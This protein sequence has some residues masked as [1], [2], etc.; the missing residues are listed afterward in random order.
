VTYTL[1]N[2]EDSTQNNLTPVSAPSEE[3][4]AD[5]RRRHRFDFVAQADDE[6][7]KRAHMVSR[8]GM[9]H[10]LTGTTVPPNKGAYC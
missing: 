4:H 1:V 7:R 6:R 8:E 3:D 2:N 9:F 5:V 10:S